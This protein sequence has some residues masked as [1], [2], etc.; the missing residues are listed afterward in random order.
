[1]EITLNNPGSDLPEFSLD[2]ALDTLEAQKFQETVLAEIRQP[3]K[4]GVIID[5]TQMPYLTSTGLRSIM[6]I[7]KAARAGGGEMAICGL[8]GLALQIFTSSGFSKIFPPAEDLETAR[9]RLA[10]K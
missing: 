6:S 1:M 10:G 4:R 2:G 5:C 8:S 3:G 7:G 9:Q